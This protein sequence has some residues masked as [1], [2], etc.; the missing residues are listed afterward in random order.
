MSGAEMTWTE[1]EPPP[2]GTP[3]MRGI[4][5]LRAAAKEFAVLARQRRERLLKEELLRQAGATPSSNSGSVVSSELLP[6]AHVN[7][8]SPSAVIPE[9]AALTTFVPTPVAP[10]PIAAEFV[11]TP[12]AA[13][14][15]A[16]AFVPTPVAPAPVAPA[17]IAAEFVPMPVAP[18]PIAAEFAPAPIAAA[19]VSTPD[20]TVIVATPG[21]TEQ[22]TPPTTTTTS[23]LRKPRPG[24]KSGT[25]AAAAP[26]APEPAAARD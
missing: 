24:K 3:C 18:A 6:V 4:L 22:E 25:P 7:V 14:P 10:A 23:S 21:N 2:Q 17:P 8:S 11:P 26:V 19:F 5:A 13:A 16:A 15:V 20:T 12:V 1:A 9:S